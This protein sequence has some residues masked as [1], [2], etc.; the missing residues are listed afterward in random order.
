MNEIEKLRAKLV[1]AEN[2]IRNLREGKK[3][4][5]R[6]QIKEHRKAISGLNNLVPALRA[7]LGEARQEIKILKTVIRM[8]ET[9]IQELQQEKV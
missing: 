5:S 7:Q 9:S 6:C 3:G 1:A 2:T 8:Q 4:K